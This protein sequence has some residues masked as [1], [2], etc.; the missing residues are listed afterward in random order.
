MNCIKSLLNKRVIN[1]S[2]GDELGCVCDI[3]VDTSCGN[4]SQLVVPM[5]NNILAIFSK[6]EFYY[7][8]WCDIVKIGNDLILVNCKFK[9]DI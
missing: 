5:K 9:K 2:T 1:I 7:I 6:D 3:L 8:N 4:V